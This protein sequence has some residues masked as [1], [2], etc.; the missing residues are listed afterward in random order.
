MAKDVFGSQAAKQFV[1]RRYS[2]QALGVYAPLFGVSV[3]LAF[4]N[5]C[6]RGQSKL[7]G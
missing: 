5:M 4:I 3:S 6:V 2:A 1:T 7:P